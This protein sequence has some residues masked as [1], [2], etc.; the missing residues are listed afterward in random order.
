MATST[1]LIRFH[2]PRHPHFRVAYRKEKAARHDA[3]NRERFSI[4]RDTAID[5]RRIA[6]ETSL[7]ERIA[8]HNNMFLTDLIFIRQKS[9]SKR[10]CNAENRKDIGTHELA[11]ESLRL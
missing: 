4:Q 7:P 6:I 9:P 2:G 10:G 1:S 5:D 11:I 8:Q 3:D